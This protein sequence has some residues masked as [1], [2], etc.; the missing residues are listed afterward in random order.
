MWRYVQKHGPPRPGEQV[1]AWRFFLDRDHGQGS[2]PSVT[3]F[4]ACQ[5]FD[6]LTRDDTAWTVV[7]AYADADLWGPTMEMIDFWRAA[8]ADYTIGG[9]D[10]P[11]VR[12]T[13]GAAPTPRNGGEPVAAPRGG[14]RRP[15]RPRTTPRIRCS[16]RRSSPPPSG[17][18]CATS[19]SRGGFG[20]TRCCGRAWCGSTREPRCRPPRRCAS[21]WSG[22]SGHCDP[23]WARSST[24]PSCARPPRR[25]GS[26][27]RCTSP[28]APTG[29]AATG[30]SPRSVT[31]CGS[32]EIGHR[33]TTG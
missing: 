17:R 27:R 28:S 7:G 6:A 31:G 24:A 18:P 21:C 9:S 2:S 11:G 3:L 16:R 30:R 5:V 32:G 8:D 10:Y 20:R 12:G 33:T 13:T 1:R 25:S 22:P 29:G 14:V 23:T 4:A 19:P 26:P 15:D